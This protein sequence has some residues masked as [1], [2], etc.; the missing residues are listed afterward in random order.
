MTA[1]VDPLAGVTTPATSVVRQEAQPSTAYQQEVNR[2]QHEAFAPP[3][4]PTEDFSMKPPKGGRIL[5]PCFR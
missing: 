1:A 4:R 3:P 5:T 2:M